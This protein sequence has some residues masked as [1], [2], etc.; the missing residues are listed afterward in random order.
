MS[1]DWH[2]AQILLE[3]WFPN[4][5]VRKRVLGLG[6]EQIM[7]TIDEHATVVRA[8]LALQAG[9]SDTSP[10]GITLPDCLL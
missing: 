7:R 4:D 2:Q 5:D 10:A 6:K 8:S 1:V 3:H 9:L